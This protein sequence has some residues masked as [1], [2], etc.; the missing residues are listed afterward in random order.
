MFLQVT[1]P[2]VI[3]ERSSSHPEDGD[4]GRSQWVQEWVIVLAALNVEQQIGHSIDRDVGDHRECVP[5][6]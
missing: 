1:F 6:R 3:Y 2:S 4:I 5:D